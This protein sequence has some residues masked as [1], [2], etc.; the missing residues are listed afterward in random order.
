[1]GQVC[2]HCGCTFVPS[3]RVKN[4]RYC[5]KADCRRAW[6]REWQRDKKKKDAEYRA[7]QKSAQQAWQKQHP[8]YW[9][10]YR[11]L[12]PARAERNRLMQRERMRELRQRK[13][14]TSNEMFAKMDSI[15]QGNPDLKSIFP[16]RYRLSPI[17]EEFAKMDSIIV[18]IR[19]IT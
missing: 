4:Q 18:E 14:A 15:F 10:E 3:P 1:M 19:A 8:D 16:G 17:S 11:K 5:G 7:N 13:Q 2:P 12:N 9:Q 6:K